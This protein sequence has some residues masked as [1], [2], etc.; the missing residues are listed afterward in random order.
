VNVPAL[1]SQMPEHDIVD[2][3]PLSIP[4]D[5]MVMLVADRL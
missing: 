1:E 2:A 5:E 4:F 3:L